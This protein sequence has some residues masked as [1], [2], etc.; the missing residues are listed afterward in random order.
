MHGYGASSSHRGR[1]KKPC[2]YPNGPPMHIKLRAEASTCI[3]SK[4]THNFDAEKQYD[5]PARLRGTKMWLNPHLMVANGSRCTLCQNP[6]G[7][8]GCFTVESCGAQFHPPCLI[9]YMIKKRSCPHCRSP[10]H[11][12]LYLQTGLLKYMPSNWVCDLQDF[13]FALGEWDGAD[14]EW[15]WRHQCLKLKNFH[16]EED[17]EWIIDPTKSSICCK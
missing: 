11:S 6:F 13:P 10:F 16:Q 7:P 3:S 15:S 5:Y 9:S 12:R 17:G 1:L 2:T 14:M 8:E 4:T